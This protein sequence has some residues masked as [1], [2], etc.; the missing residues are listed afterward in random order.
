MN[1]N[2]KWRVLLIVGITVIA[3]GF[4]YP[5]TRTDWSKFPRTNQVNLGLDLQGGM[6]VV[7]RADVEK[8]P[9]DAQKDAI[10]R[11]R[12]IVANRVDEFGVKETSITRQGENHI[13]VQ[14]PGVTDRQRTIDIL[15]RTAHLEFKLVASDSDLINKALSGDVPPGYEV[16]VSQGRGEERLVLQSDTQVTGDKLV[17]AKVDFDQF[18]KPVVS[19]ELSSQGAKQFSELTQRSI[20][21]RLA[22][23]LDDKIHSA[24]VIQTQIP[25]GRGQITG[26]FTFEEA[27]DLAIVLRAGALPVPVIVEEER[28]VGPSLGQDSIDQGMRAIWLGGIAVLIFMAS[29]YWI[30][31]MIA[32]IALFLNILIIFAS[33]P[34]LHAS[35]TLPGLAGI[36][37]TI[38][39]AVDANVLIYERMRE[40]KALGKTARTLIS[41]AYHKA[42][43]PIFDSNLT[44]IIAAVLLFIFGT[45]PIKG[46]AITLTVGLVVSLFTS[47][48]V[49][50]TIFDFLSRGKKE[51]NLAMMKLIG[52]PKTDYV[53]LRFAA[54]ALSLVVIIVGMG[55]FISRG[56]KNYGVDFAGGLLQQIEFKEE[57]NMNKVRASLEE[58]GIKDPQIQNFKEKGKFDIIIR[59]AKDQSHEIEQALTKLVGAENL[60]VVRVET[61]GP[62][63]GKLLREKA[64]WAITFA[65]LSIC[66][67]VGFRFKS[68]SYSLG[69]I[70]SL[71]HDVVVALG[72]YAICGREV[73]LTIVASLLTLAG[74]SI[75]DTIVTFDRIRDNL[76]TMRKETFSQ[77][78]NISI[79][80]T[81][82]RTIL[83]SLTTFI[84]TAILFFFGG[85]AINDFALIMLVGL[86]TGSYSTIFIAAPILVEWN[87]GKR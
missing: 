4:L 2:F 42:F 11:V 59:T 56:D 3:L 48:F 27:S 18:G 10:E 58:A 20:G 6:H 13:V 28:I 19:F 86:V 17:D 39:M 34:L 40:E 29:Y 74:Y 43:L 44:T 35:L 67:Y 83:T 37:L 66:I 57:M 87:K 32:D 84:V 30:C 77:I 33:L 73:N 14:L 54:Y 63:V 45:G 16:K 85:S 38:G 60:K 61:V 36:V 71:V 15:K 51:V 76:K 69:A 50:R 47:L 80:Q 12:E 79:N 9:K 8:L 46:F 72:I 64:L 5:P 62:A 23:V 65:I 75:N 53:K 21:R 25:D 31:G 70:V 52:V 78:I 22:I 7:L 1:K 26:N 81:L 24:P 49:T 55:A 68:L 41:S 82:A